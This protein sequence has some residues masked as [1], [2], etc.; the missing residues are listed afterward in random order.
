M[1]QGYSVNIIVCP[2]LFLFFFIL[3]TGQTVSHSPSNTR[4]SFACLEPCAPGA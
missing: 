2:F 3:L 4:F 1:T